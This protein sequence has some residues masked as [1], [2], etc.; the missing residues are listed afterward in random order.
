MNYLAKLR[1][2]P[3]YIPK[4]NLP[5]LARK[6]KQF[7]KCFQPRPGNVFIS[8][9]VVSLEP[10]ITAEFSK[11]PLYRYAVYEGIGKPAHMSRGI[12]MIDDVYL[13]TAS[14][15]P[16]TKDGAQR[17]YEAG[18]LAN[19]HLLTEDDRDPIKDKCKKTVRNPAKTAALGLGYGM[20]WRKLQKTSGEAGFPISAEVAKATKDAYWKNFEGLAALRDYLSWEIKKKGA[21]VNPFGYRLTPEPHKAFNAYIQSSAS[22]VMDVYGRFVLHGKSPILFVACIHDEYIFEIPESYVDEFKERSKT[23]VKDLNDAL[24]W[25]CP[26]RFGTK[27]GNNFSELK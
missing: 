2:K 7:M 23:A 11:D 8:Q 3:N 18:E 17:F 5:A 21:T 24:G 14:F 6:H 1:A 13:M 9:D 22:G 16:H 10:T 12:L 19:W 4:V 27:I 15:L 25:E 26:I 20:G